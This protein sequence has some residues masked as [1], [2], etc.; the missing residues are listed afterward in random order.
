MTHEKQ[1]LSAGWQDKSGKTVLFVANTANTAQTCT[2]ILS[3]DEYNAIAD[4]YDCEDGQLQVISRDSD[5]IKLSATVAPDGII[6]V[7]F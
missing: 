2:L 6:T 7:S 4:C 3:A 1:V 5:V